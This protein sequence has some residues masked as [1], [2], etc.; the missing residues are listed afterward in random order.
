MSIGAK[1]KRNRQSVKT[2]PVIRKRRIKTNAL[3][4][5]IFRGTTRISETRRCSAGVI[6][7]GGF[8]IVLSGAV[9]RARVSTY[10]ELAGP[11][12][13]QLSAIVLIK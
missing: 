11:D 7:P 4:S 3:R 12:V 13:C 10:I 2:G 1:N 6:S 8:R 9:R 5:G